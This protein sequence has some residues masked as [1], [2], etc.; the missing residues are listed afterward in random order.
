MR[1]PKTTI[2]LQ[3]YASTA[4]GLGTFTT[5]WSDIRNI[6]GVFWTLSGNERLAYNKLTEDISHKF[7]FDNLIGETITTKDR[8]RLTDGTIYDI[9]F[10]DATADRGKFTV[11][12]L[13]EF[14]T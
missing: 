5:T 13:R 3:R 1:G 7:A 14:K 2:V 9:K 6:K 10:I 11:L 4:D 12:L 8:L